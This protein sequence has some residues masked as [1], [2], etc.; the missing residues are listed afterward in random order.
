ML[1][2]GDFCVSGSEEPGVTL[3]HSERSGKTYTSD[4]CPC[5]TAMHI[6]EDSSFL[7]MT[8][9]KKQKS[10]QLL[11]DGFRYYLLSNVISQ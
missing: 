6:E 5:N 2:G 8:R 10:H 4:W 7:R 11:V 1:Q 3:C 9:G